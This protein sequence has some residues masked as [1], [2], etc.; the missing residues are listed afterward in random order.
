MRNWLSNSK[1]VVC[2]LNDAPPKYLGTHDELQE[3]VLGMWW[4]PESDMLTF[5]IKPEL[6]QRSSAGSHTKRRVLSIVMSIFD[7]LGLLR[8][9]NVRAKIIL[10][11]IW[12]SGVS[13]DEA[14][15]EP[16]EIDWMKWQALLPKLSDLRFPRYMSCS[17]N[18]KSLQLHMF[19]DASLD[20]YAASS[21]FEPIS[22]PRIELMA[23]VLG[24]RL[25]KC[26]ESELSNEIEKRVFWTDAQD[27][28]FWIRSD[29]RKYPQF[30]ALR[31]GEILKGS[32]VGEWRWVPSEQNV[33]DDG[34][35][36]TKGVE[37][38]SSIRWFSG[39][40]YL[41]QDESK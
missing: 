11:N 22:V 25:A 36:W 28:L 7:P 15:K 33:A 31:V 5:V 2:S 4:L 16:D 1:R 29:A 12:R 3:K 8:F 37:V 30:V 41:L 17:S 21:T 40:N 19:V 9:F 20:A 18:V 14:I 10:Q 34:T 24:L 23:A 38:N 6:L 35:K 32:E 39:P 13:W 26:L 27:V